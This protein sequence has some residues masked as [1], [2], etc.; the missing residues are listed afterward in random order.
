M[1]SRI[2]KCLALVLALLPLSAMADEF[3]GD[4]VL[5][6]SGEMQQIYGDDGKPARLVTVEERDGAYWLN[7][8]GLMG[9]GEPQKAELQKDGKYLAQWLGW[10]ADADAP[11]IRSTALVGD[12]IA[13]FHIAKGTE[14]QSANGRSHVMRTD[15]LLVMPGIDLALER[16]PADK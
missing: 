3:V 8:Q 4:Y 10:G 5:Q 6:P 9:S 1:F 2:G 13:L 16:A 12:R 11:A 15:Y 7:V 14:L